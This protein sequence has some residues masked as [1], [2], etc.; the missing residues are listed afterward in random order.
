MRTNHVLQPTTGNLKNDFLHTEVSTNLV[1]SYRYVSSVRSSKTAVD[2]LITPT[3]ESLAVD[4]RA[5]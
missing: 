4:H 1:F 2:G 5:R 3:D